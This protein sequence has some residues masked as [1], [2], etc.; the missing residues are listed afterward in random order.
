MR[1][2]ARYVIRAAAALLLSPTSLCLSATRAV[3][4]AASP[5]AVSGAAHADAGDLNGEI[6]NLAYLLGKW[7]CKRLGSGR[8]SVTTF[9][10][11]G[12]NTIHEHDSRAQRSESD[13]YFGYDPTAHYYYMTMAN[14]AGTYGYAYSSDGVHFSYTIRAGLDTSDKV[15][16]SIQH[17]STDTLAFHGEAAIN[18]M[19]TAGDS[20]CSR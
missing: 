5:S 9:E 19:K 2:L 3:A 6:A 14:S 18:G 17:P 11:A 4:D 8:T 15:T 1:T 13:E 16:F 12:G 10:V 20:T 7:T